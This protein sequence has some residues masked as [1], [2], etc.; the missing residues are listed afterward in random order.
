MPGPTTTAN[1][2]AFPLQTQAAGL[3]THHRTLAS[4]GRDAATA[5]RLAGA[6]HMAESASP[7]QNPRDQA[8]RLRDLVA[9]MNGGAK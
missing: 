8:T 5:A 7:A 3:Y 6:F 2:P 9:A 1:T 4:I